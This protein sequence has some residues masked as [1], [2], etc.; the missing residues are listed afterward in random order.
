MRSLVGPALTPFALSFTLSSTGR[1]AAL[2]EAL[3]AQ[4]ERSNPDR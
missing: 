3:E 1:E 4:F 2:T